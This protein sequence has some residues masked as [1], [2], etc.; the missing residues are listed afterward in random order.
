MFA[1]RIALANTKQQCGNVSASVVPPM[2]K[3]LLDRIDYF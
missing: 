2:C 1:A 3:S